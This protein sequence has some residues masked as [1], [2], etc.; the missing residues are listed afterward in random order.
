MRDDNV[1]KAR[2][3]EN[4]VENVAGRCSTISESW[5]VCSVLIKRSTHSIKPIPWEALSVH[6]MVS[7]SNE[8]IW[9]E[10]C[11]FRPESFFRA[12]LDFQRTL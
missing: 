9:V 2:L 10:C 4:G 12:M 8:M 1:G 6:S 7:H 5:S 11:R 3:V